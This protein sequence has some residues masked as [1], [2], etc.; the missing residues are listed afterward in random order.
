MLDHALALAKRG[1]KVFPIRAGTKNEPLVK[2][3]EWATQ[4]EGKIRVFWTHQPDS[5]I[6]IDCTGLLVIDVDPRKGGDILAFQSKHQTLNPTLTHSTPSGGDHFIYRSSRPI[7]N[8]VDKLGPGIDVRGDGGYIVG[9]G[10]SRPDG[11][12]K[13]NSD[14]QIEAAQPWLETLAGEKTAAVLPQGDWVNDGASRQVAAEFLKQAAP[15]IQGEGGDLHTFQVCADLAKIGLEPAIALELLWEHWNPRC[16]PPWGL[17]ELQIK[18]HNG[19][20]YRTQ[21][22]VFE[23]FDEIPEPAEVQT[24]PLLAKRE[25]PIIR[26]NEWSAQ[27][28]IQWL[29]KRLIAKSE[30]AVMYGPSGSGKTFLALDLAYS[31]ARGSPFGSFK[32]KQAQVVYLGMEGYGGLRKR[33]LAYLKAKGLE[34]ASGI[35]L[36]TVPIQVPF[37]NVERFKRLLAAV[38]KEFP[39]L[40]LIVVDTYSKAMAGLD[41]NSAKDVNRVLTFL[42]SFVNKTGIS[43]MLIHHTGKETTKGMRGSSAFHAGVSTVIEVGAKKFKLTKQKDGPLGQEFP[44]I[45]PTVPLGQ[46]DDGETIDSCVVEH[47]AIEDFKKPT[48]AFDVL[49]D[50]SPGDEPTSTAASIDPDDDSR[51]AKGI[52]AYRFALGH[53]LDKRSVTIEEWTTQLRLAYYLDLDDDNFRK[54]K[55]KVKKAMV[56]LGYKERG[57]LFLEPK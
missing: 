53:S 5:N 40:G 21:S 31:V 18:L 34:F 51:L 44:F 10:S 33:N 28:P 57:L 23:E 6:G 8:S 22:S 9:P 3:R 50:V 4:D 45:L 16:E 2:W 38:L 15:A 32:T 1:F 48:D 37:E 47:K 29:V 20:A 39:A 43:V 12:Y 49:I 52:K 25:F 13:V 55:S 19:Y 35:P 54:I 24:L 11:Q 7:P 46:D 17:E 30:L 41:E 26:P 27:P 42:E 14:W 56:D 36:G